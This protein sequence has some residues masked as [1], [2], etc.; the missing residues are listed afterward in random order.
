MQNL[1]DLTDERCVAEVI[2]SRTLPD[3]CSGDSSHQIP[4]GDTLGRFRNLLI[5]S[6]LQEKLYAHVV[7]MLME[8]GMILKKGAIVDSSIIA[9]FSS[10]K[11]K[12][13]QR[14]PE[15]K[16]VKKG[17]DWHFGYKTAHRRG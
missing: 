4:N 3:F 11:N 16:S 10:T 7:K 5:R 9:A 12:E 15:T 14:E 17:N 1:Y 6:G 13:K 2:N 8:R